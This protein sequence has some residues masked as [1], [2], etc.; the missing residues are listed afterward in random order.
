[1]SSVELGGVPYSWK[2]GSCRVWYSPAAPF[3]PSLPS[4]P[5][6]HI[7]SCSSA[8]RA[9]FSPAEFSPPERRGSCFPSPPVS[10]LFLRPQG[11]LLACSPRGAHGCLLRVL[12]LDLRSSHTGPAQRLMRM[13][14]SLQHS[15]APRGGPAAKL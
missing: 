5:D 8:C 15:M 13:R 6:L 3:P 2:R 7:C 4:P 11:A 1:M 12:H 14:A 10:H 9:L